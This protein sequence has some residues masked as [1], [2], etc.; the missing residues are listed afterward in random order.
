[1]VLHRIWPVLFFFALGVGAQ[2]AKTAPADFHSA[3]F[4][5]RERLAAKRL[6]R[7]SQFVDVPHVSARAV[8]RN[9]Q[10]PQA[11]TTPDPLFVIAA[12]G[13]RVKVSFIIGT[14]GRVHSPL[15]LESAGLSG[16]RDVLEIVRGWRY[17]PATC[18]GVP[19][20]IEGKVEF[21]SQ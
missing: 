19:T 10:P 5:R 17:R 6:I 21:S 16:D 3:S 12:Y 15:I 14:D 9:V 7:A 18:D 1:M 8:C 13:R 11:L 4:E 20:E 2:A